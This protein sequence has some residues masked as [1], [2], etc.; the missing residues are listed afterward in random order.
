MINC[1]KK[2]NTYK[3]SGF[4]M[5]EMLVAVSVF[6]ML[7][8]GVFQLQKTATDTFSIASWKAESQRTLVTGLKMIRDDI[9]KATYPSKIFANGSMIYSTNVPSAFV[10]KDPSPDKVNGG[11]SGIDNYFLKY[12]AG[13]APMPADG[14][15]LTLITYYI[16]A[17]VYADNDRIMA[18][19]EVA[20]FDKTQYQSA[21]QI[22]MSLILQ[23]KNAAI[24]YPTLAYKVG[25]T[26][27]PKTIMT[28]V[29]SVEI[30]KEDVYPPPGNPPDVN[31]DVNLGKFY[32]IYE[33]YA[34]LNIKIEL[35]PASDTRIT[36]GA[37]S[38]FSTIKIVDNIRARTNV[39]AVAN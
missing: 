23:A 26:G 15:S 30:T 4:T 36:R 31:N 13:V 33:I 28:H 1:Y 9:E 34:V 8:M 39:H 18:K 35:S 10:L 7:F 5:V 27:V 2:I 6:A 17:P 14:G 22:Q 24:P 38:A 37:G 29:Q 20:S 32:S 21:P 19:S 16:C 3:T 11:I 25:A 12:K